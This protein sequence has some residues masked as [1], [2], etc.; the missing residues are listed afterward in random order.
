ME[1]DHFRG[2][3]MDHAAQPHPR[4]MEQYRYAD[5]SE[6]ERGDAVWLPPDG[7]RLYRIAGWLDGARVL[8]VPMSGGG[9][10]GADAV[11]VSRWEP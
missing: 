6:M 11:D 1:R 8:L 7:S 3:R 4:E 5:G 2:E 9:A 10:V